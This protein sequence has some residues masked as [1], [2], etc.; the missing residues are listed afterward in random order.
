MENF[1]K[2]KLTTWFKGIFKKNYREIGKTANAVIKAYTI[3]GKGSLRDS[4]KKDGEKLQAMNESGNY[5]LSSGF[6]H[7]TENMSFLQRVSAL[8]R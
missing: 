4:L 8:A 3:D 1:N 5:K 2:E 6:R 7:T